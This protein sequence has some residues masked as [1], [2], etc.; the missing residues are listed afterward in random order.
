[1]RLYK[2]RQLRNVQRATIWIAAFAC[3]SPLSPLHAQTAE[4]SAQHSK[5]FEFHS[6]LWINLHHFLYMQALASVPEAG[7]RK[8][9]S[10]SNPDSDEL[11]NLSADEKAIWSASL[12]Y[13]RHSMISRD[14]LFDHGMEEIKNKLEDSESAIE[15]GSI[16]IPDDLRLVLKRAAPIYRK[17]WWPKHEAQNQRW[18]AA[19]NPLIQKHADSLFKALTTI[20]EEPWPGN[21]VRVDAVVYANWAGAYT[22][23][24]PT[25]V[26]VSTSDPSNQGTAALE[27]IFHE[28]SHGMMN[29]VIDALNDAEQTLNS[30]RKNNPI[31]FRR[32]LW[33]EVLFYTSGELVRQRVP[34]YVPYADQNGLWKRA[35]TGSDRALIERDWKPHMNGSEERQQ[36]LTRLVEELATLGP[37]ARSGN[38]SPGDH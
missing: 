9:V 38:N 30:K 25:R 34:G 16:A 32:D 37:G 3:M 1:M 4:P 31:E 13:Y 29:K 19:L 24:E 12:D 7:K 10:V 35:F 33:H 17:H 6:G 36:S 8:P 26:T 20:Y 5:L 18:I 15:T 28:V 11:K 23:L 2:R 21:P 27:V 22:S 14:L